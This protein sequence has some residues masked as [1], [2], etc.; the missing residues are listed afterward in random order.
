[1]HD[2]ISSIE[3]RREAGQ[4]DEDIRAELG[5]P[6]K[7]AAELNEQ[8]KDYTFRKSPW[9]WVCLTVA[10]C[11]GVT[12]LFGGVMAVITSLLQASLSASIGIIGGAD[13]P[14]AIFVTASP[15]SGIGATAIVI[16]LLI[17]S[18]YG[19]YRLSRCKRK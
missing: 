1:V 3:G 2:L 8:M 14:T 7:A 9:R 16:V 13:G 12:L 4:T 5:T 10:V 19:F 17:G 11:S 18:I 6:A 15:D